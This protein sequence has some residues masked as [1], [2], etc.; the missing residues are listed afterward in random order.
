MVLAVFTLAEAKKTKWHQLNG[1]TF[2]KY[3]M[4]FGKSYAPEEYAARKNI[5][6]EKLEKI[7]AHNN[8]PTKTWKSG[9][10][11]L[12]DLSENVGR[13][14]L[15]ILKIVVGIHQHVGLRKG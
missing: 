1:Y 12:T 15:F 6:E 5:F 10:N 7:R 2:D 14:N 3:V 13:N 8:D 9:V 11:H 4:E